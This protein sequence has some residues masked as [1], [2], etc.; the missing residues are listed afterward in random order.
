MMD[1]VQNFSDSKFTHVDSE[2]HCK[3][4]RLLCLHVISILSLAF[5]GILLP[6]ESGLSVSGY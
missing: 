3:T 2:V 4:P 5:H 6:N 1:K